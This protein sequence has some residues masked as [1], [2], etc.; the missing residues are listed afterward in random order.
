MC[1]DG[2]G[3][4]RKARLSIGE[5]SRLHSLTLARVAQDSSVRDGPRCQS[6]ADEALTAL[7]RS[8]SRP[9]S[10]SC[11]QIDHARPAQRWELLGFPK[12]ALGWQRLLGLAQKCWG[13]S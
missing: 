6:L 5:T 8:D 1:G 12:G 11:P 3:P 7:N 2:Q 13:F 4:Q 9:W 10:P